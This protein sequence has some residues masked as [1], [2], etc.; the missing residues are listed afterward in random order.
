MALK[1]S[2][3]GGGGQLESDFWLWEQWRLD[4][5]ASQFPSS[6]DILFLLL[7][8]NIPKVAALCAGSS[9]VKRA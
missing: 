8:L 2:G 5:L 6:R 7:L 9:D 3:V 4:E 1:S